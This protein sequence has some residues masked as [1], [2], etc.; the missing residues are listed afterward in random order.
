[1]FDPRPM[2]L[3]NQAG[4]S[5]RVL[6]LALNY[7]FSPKPSILQLSVPANKAAC[8]MDHSYSKIDPVQNYLKKENLVKISDADLVKIEKATRKQDASKTWKQERLKRLTASNFGAIH[9]A[10]KRSTKDKL[11]KR[12]LTHVNLNSIPAIR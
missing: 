1:M 10:K 7:K 3:R 6:N 4:Y 8:D 12:M 2:E 9:R 5:D 11:A